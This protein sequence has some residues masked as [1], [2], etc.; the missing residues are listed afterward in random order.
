MTLQKN[1]RLTIKISA[2]AAEDLKDIWDYVAQH[3]EHSAR[4]LIQEIKKISCSS[5]ISRA[6]SFTSEL[7]LK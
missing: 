4:K 3:D 2:S 1:N 7:A 6:N 5:R